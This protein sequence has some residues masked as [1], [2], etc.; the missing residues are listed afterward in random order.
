MHE[1]W[2]QQGA[3]ARCPAGAARPPLHSPTASS[4]AP[5]PSWAASCR[6][7]QTAPPRPV[8]RPW[9]AG[10]GVGA[11]GGRVRGR[12]RGVRGREQPNA[13]P[14]IHPSPTRP[15]PAPN[16]APQPPAQFSPAH[17]LA[18]GVGV[19]LG[20]QH[21][22][23]HVLAR[24]EHVV[25][26]RVPNLPGGWRGGE[27]W[28]EEHGEKG[29]GSSCW[30]QGQV[31]IRGRWR[32]GCRMGRADG[33]AATSAAAAPARKPR[34]PPPAAAH[35][36]RPAV[37]THDPHRGLVQAVGVVLQM[38]AVGAAAVAQGEA[39]NT[40]ASARQAASR[41][42]WQA[43]GRHVKAGGR[44]VEASRKHVEARGSKQHASARQGCTPQGAPG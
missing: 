1:G 11:G 20:V 25:H 33:L 17:L 9:T 19:L 27:G 31:R 44:H 26:A 43:S 4:S 15:K 36:V 8:G 6:P 34:E 38:G 40:L 16:R 14:G 22:H 37:A 42:Q 13:C 12:A 18:A 23:V 10:R 30:E 35:V 3:G 7:P 39:V 24:G 29:Q 2:Q 41:W 28:G 5:A 21:Q 32:A